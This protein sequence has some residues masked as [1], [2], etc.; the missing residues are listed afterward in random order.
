MKTAITYGYDRRSKVP[1]IAGTKPKLC[2]KCNRWFAAGKRH[3]VCDVCTRSNRADL[4]KPA[5]K[6]TRA[7][8]AR[9]AKITAQNPRSACRELALEAVA[10]DHANGKSF[11]CR[12]PRE[13]QAEIIPAHRGRRHPGKAD[14]P[15]WSGYC[16]GPCACK[17]HTPLPDMSDATKMAY[18]RRNV[19]LGLQG[20]CDLV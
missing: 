8:R 17:C 1:A 7:I 9:R 18:T 14:R 6:S 2:P 20:K 4:Q 11:G 5:V 16:V 15:E 13:Q 3:R 12:Y 10:D 19:N